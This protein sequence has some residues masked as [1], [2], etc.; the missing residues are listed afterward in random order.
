MAIASNPDPVGCSGEGCSITSDTGSLT[1]TVTYVVTAGGVPSAFTAAASLGP[2]APAPA[3][4]RL[5]VRELPAG[6]PGA[7]AP[8]GE[9][10]TRAGRWSS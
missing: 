7:A 5:R 1:L 3:S 6:R 9:S 8:R 2:G 10:V 4:R